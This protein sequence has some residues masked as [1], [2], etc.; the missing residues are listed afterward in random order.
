MINI[1]KFANNLKTNRLESKIKT[2]A[3]TPNKFNYLFQQESVCIL[4]Y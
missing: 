1:N 2:E 4:K 3:A